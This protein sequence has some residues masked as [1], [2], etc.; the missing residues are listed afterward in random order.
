MGMNSSQMM[1]NDTPMDIHGL[2]TSQAL[3]LNQSY[4]IEKKRRDILMLYEDINKVS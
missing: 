3:N 2:N 4:Y 1:N